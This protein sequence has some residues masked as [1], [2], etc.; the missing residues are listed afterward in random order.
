MNL[1]KHEKKV[2]A[3]LLDNGRVPD[4]EMAAQLNISTQA[5]GKIRK[6]LEDKRVIE[7]YTCSVNF[8]KMGLHVFAVTLE[9][10]KGK[11]WDDLGEVEGVEFI[12]NN[13][14]SI[15]SCM[16]LG[17][18]VSVINLHAFR[19]NKEMDRYFHLTRARSHTYIDV[20]QVYPTSSLHFLKNNPKELFKLLLSGQSLVPA[21]VKKVEV[22]SKKTIN[23]REETR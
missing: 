14:A 4:V 10:L 5:V 11:Y 3:L 21:E 1:T 17:S 23:Y 16:P 20:K 12:K 6:K 18:D 2:L 7:G 22:Q 8:E 19:D 13:P 9:R 15:F